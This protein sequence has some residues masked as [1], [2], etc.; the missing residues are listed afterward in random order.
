MG[1]STFSMIS[2]AKILGK[3]FDENPISVWSFFFGLILAS[4]Y[5]VGC[6]VEKWK[7]DPILFFIIGI[8]IY[9]PNRKLNRIYKE[10]KA[11]AQ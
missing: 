7:L 4:V 3:L 10:N 2:I 8:N 1:G 9:L 6:R 11:K 5:Y